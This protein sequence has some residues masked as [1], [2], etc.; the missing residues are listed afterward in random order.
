MLVRDL[1]R[2]IVGVCIG[3]R[4][5][6]THVTNG[7]TCIMPIPVNSSTTRATT[8]MTFAAT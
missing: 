7:A 4:V 5:D 2:A 8:A 6:I 3:E 1:A